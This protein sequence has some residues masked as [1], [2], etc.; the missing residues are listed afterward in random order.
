MLTRRRL[1]TVCTESH[2]SM[3][4]KK[5]ALS[6]VSEKTEKASFLVFAM[7][8]FANA[9]GAGA[10]GCCIFDGPPVTEEPVQQRDKQESQLE[11]S[12]S[13]CS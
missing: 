6:I 4:K 12:A 7:A 5:R 3:R 1:K 8:C 9:A 10:P 2:E 11:V 13:T